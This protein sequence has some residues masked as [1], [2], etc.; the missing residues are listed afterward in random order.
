VVIDH[1]IYA[2]EDLEV[3]AAR[4]R[5]EHG[6]DSVVGGRHPGWGTANRIVPLGREY[7]EL[8]A[9]VDEAQAAESEF[10]RLVVGALAA[11]R[12]LVGWA[13]ATDDLEGVAARLDLAVVEGARHRPDGSALHWRAAGI[14]RALADGAL[15][16]FIQWDVPANLHPSAT[17]V[18]HR[19]KPRGFG[20]IEIT[21]EEH[22]VRAWLG[23]HDLPLRVRRGDPALAAAAIDTAEG[24]VVLG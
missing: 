21:G 17:P 23:E 20:W 19:A 15:P 6:L 24:E 2:V 18:G 22:S 16:F 5:D 14:A 11:E 3:A 13:V 12:R 9:V 4:F 1:V 8:V 10:G 7:L